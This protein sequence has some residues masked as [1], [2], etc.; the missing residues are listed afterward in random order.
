MSLAAALQLTSQDI[1]T[2]SNNSN[3]ERLGQP[4][5]TA[6]GRTFVF[7][8]SGATNLVA[9]KL[10][11]SLA[12]IANHVNRTG[13]TAA[14]GTQTFT[15]TL[16]ATLATVGQYGGG[17]LIINAGTGAGQALRIYGN[18]SAVS[19]GSIT[20]N[21]SDALAVA[22]SVTDSKFSLL[23]SFYG[24]TVLEDHTAAPA[25]PITGVPPLAV[26]AGLFYWSQVGGYASVLSDGII[27][28]NIGGI[29]SA[30]V[31][32]AVVTE[33]TTTIAKRIGYAPEATVDTNYSP[34]VLT[35][36]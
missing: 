20:V 36:A 12:S 15:F 10:T 26:G 19:S 22:T 30:S 14:I 13:V 7:A 3:G 5:A 4:M 16:G 31:D 28:K 6:D 1:N 35:L 23:P 33:A 32:G 24:A 8:K 18:T 25:V 29:P 34:F 17:Y 9:G 11:Q 2:T 21:T 27:A